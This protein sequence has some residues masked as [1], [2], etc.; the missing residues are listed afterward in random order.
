M[1]AVVPRDP[2][3][4]LP[5]AV[6]AMPVVGRA[7]QVRPLSAAGGTGLTAHTVTLLAMAGTS[8][9]QPV[10]LRKPL[11]A[12]GPRRRTATS[13]PAASTEAISRNTASMASP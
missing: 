2:G 10:S 5:D 9:G 3:E 11:C 12:T 4:E 6:T 1:A 8:W 7:L 13:P